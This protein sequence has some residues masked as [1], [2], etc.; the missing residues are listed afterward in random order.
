MQ[1][2]PRAPYSWRVRT[3]GQGV[4]LF[5]DF[6]GVLHLARAVMGQYRP[7]LAGDG[8]L[9]MWA[10]NLTPVLAAHPH[11]QIVLSTS[12]VR[13]LP[14]EQVRDFLPVLVR[15]R[16][17]GSTWHRIQTDPDFSRGLQFSYW[18]DAS[19]YQQVKRRANV[20]RLRRWVAIDDDAEGWGDADRA[21]L[22]QT[23]PERG[24]GDP[25]AVAR[26]RAFVCV[27]S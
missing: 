22:I 23:D 16:V 21:R 26:L 13:H 2:F 17:V 11:V 8:S 24:L 7:E 9:F 15:R 12:W 10:D 3:G 5:L 6:D 27:S 19:R 14:F 4:I 20:H 25:A 1:R 18:Q